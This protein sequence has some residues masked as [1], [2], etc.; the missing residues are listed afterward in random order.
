MTDETKT[1]I[2]DKV[3]AMETERFITLVVASCFILFM[4][5]LT[6]CSIHMNTFNAGEEKIES[7]QIIAKAKARTAE[8]LAEVDVQK[9]ETQGEI[10]I[11]KQEHEA[12]MERLKVVERLIKDQDVDPIAARCA[13][14]G[15]SESNNPVV[16]QQVVV[17]SP[18]P[19]QEPQ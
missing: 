19:K 4:L 1:G 18:I 13:V 8:I 10:D 14:E 16:C 5:M 9:A 17:G 15:W 3:N 6:T 11:A 2:I 12:E 7:A